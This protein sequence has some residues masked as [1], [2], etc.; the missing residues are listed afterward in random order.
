MK[1]ILI[2][3]TPLNNKIYSFF[4]VIQ[5]IIMLESI[6][7]RDCSKKTIVKIISKIV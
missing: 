1:Y 5:R 7:E 4:F 3:T 2:F 6:E